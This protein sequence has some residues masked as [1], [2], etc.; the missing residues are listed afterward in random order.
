MIHQFCAAF[1]IGIALF[2]SLQAKGIET[3]LEE[4]LE[5][6]KI[7]EYWKEKDY[8][9]VKTRIDAFLNKNPTGSHT[10]KLYA[11]LGDLHFLEKNYAEAVAAYEKIDDKALRLK[12]QFQRLHSL[13]EIKNYEE[14]VRS[15]YLFLND[16]NAKA[17]QIN[18]I[19]FELAESYFCIAHNPENK[20]GKKEL[21][22][23][24]LSLYQQCTQTRFHGMSLQPQAVI[25]TFL[26]Q[27]SE[28]VSLYLQLANK[29]ATNREAWLFQAANHQL[30]FDK[31]AAIESFGEILRIEGKH[32]PQAAFNYLSLLFQ[33][34][35]YKDF[36]LTHETA[37]KHMASENAPLMQYYLGKSLLQTA[38]FTHAIEPLSLALNSKKLDRS[39]EKSALLALCA[40]AKETQDLPLFERTLTQ[41]RAE[42]ESDEEMNN[43]L[44]MHAQL[45]RA[46]KEW[47]KA[48][49]S[50]QEILENAPHH[51]Q[52]EAFFYDIALLYTHEGKTLEG[53]VA[54]EMFMN[55]FPKSQQRQSALRNL[56]SLRLEDT[57]NTSPSTQKVKKEFLVRTLSTALGE[58]NFLSPLEKQK[59]RLLLGKMLFEL[60]H[61]EEAIG[62]LTAYTRDYSKDPS[63][64]EAY[65]LLAYCHKQD[66]NDEVHFT[67]N[68]EKAL[69]RNPELAGNGDI[70]LSL[71]NTYLSLAA[72]ASPDEKSELIAKA[73]DHLF[74]ARDKSIQ[75]ENQR[76]LATYYSQQHQN[77]KAILVLENLLQIPSDSQTIS[78][79]CH[80]ID[81]EGEALKLA[82]IYAEAGQM[83]KRV[84]LLEALKNAQSSQPDLNWKYRRMTEFELAKA[85]EALGEKEKAIHVYEDLIRSSSH[86]SSYFAL[87]AAAERAKLLFSLLQSCERTEESPV[88][89]AICDALKDV[90]VQR[91]LH[92]EPLHLEAA[93]CYVDIK[94]ELAPAEQRAERRRFLLEQ[95]KDNFSSTQDPLVEEYLSASSQFPEKKELFSSYM[96]YVDAEIQRLEGK[97][98]AKSTLDRLLTESTNDILNAR[99]RRSREAL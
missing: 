46:Q 62:P 63:C 61:Y 15:S 86:S 80:E 27:H 84:Q 3:S 95:M 32:A 75:K 16:P 93:L 87:A 89:L 30:H 40:A 76:W 69:A 74:L 33:E 12:S 29:E 77:E 17:E 25:H 2:S 28:A 65:L 64:P 22:Q 39:Q 53:T 98:E 85:W 94:T 8:K 4:S 54:F 81:K 55:E 97:E 13:Y 70:H 78:M 35:R 9:T 19:R 18:T 41:L 92:S 51:P 20:A 14:L 60:G 50:L 21:F 37:F 6:R 57:K 23:K 73:A 44:L 5:L 31:K 91:K 49:V 43:I 47:T 10:D 67:L 58:K 82:S 26:G 42:F 45:C 11:M 7:G 96:H 72:K 52:R 90:Q 68:A 1:F 59:M 71:Y 66:D 38:D 48:R 79:Q 34:K 88:V 56:I 83:Q 24:A 99:I 36:I